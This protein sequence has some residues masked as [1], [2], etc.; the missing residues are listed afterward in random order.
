MKTD[1]VK[2]LFNIDAKTLNFAEL[3][4]LNKIE[5]AL[6]ELQNDGGHCQKRRRHQIAKPG[7][8]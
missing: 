2:S 4:C 7:A 8:P 1:N 5:D 3:H 6:T